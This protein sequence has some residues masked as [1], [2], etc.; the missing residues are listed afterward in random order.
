M[1]GRR[2]EPVT[3]FDPTDEDR[4]WAR[5]QTDALSNGRP[6]AIICPITENPERMWNE[7]RYIELG[8]AL[9]DEAT[10]VFCH[11]PGDAEAIRQSVPRAPCRIRFR[12]VMKLS[13]TKRKRGQ[14][15][16]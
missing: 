14:I 5:E 9:A 8:R 7:Q 10:V 3:R 15:C 13:G 11:A 6:V 12:Y 4:A 16:S 1:T 2:G